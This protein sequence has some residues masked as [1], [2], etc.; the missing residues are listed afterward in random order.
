MWKRP[1]HQEQSEIADPRVEYARLLAEQR[2][3]PTGE[4][5]LRQAPPPAVD[6]DFCYDEESHQ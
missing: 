3:R 2:S 5:R 4:E 6:A 1:R